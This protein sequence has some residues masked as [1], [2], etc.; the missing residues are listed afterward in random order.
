[1]SFFHPWVELNPGSVEDINNYTED[2]INKPL[3]LIFSMNETEQFPLT[4][5]AARKAGKAGSRVG[6]L[7]AL[8]SILTA[9]GRRPHPGVAAPLPPRRRSSAD[10]G[11]PVNGGHDMGRL[12]Q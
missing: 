11:Y 9:V 10:E 4:T 1:L 3:S 7:L 5:G 12:L 2:S 6:R 8:L